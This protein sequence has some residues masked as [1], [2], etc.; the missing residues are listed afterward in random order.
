[1][2]VSLILKCN[3][4]FPSSY[5]YWADMWSFFPRYCHVCY[6]SRPSQILCSNG[7]KYRTCKVPVDSW[8]YIFLHPVVTSSALGPNIPLSTVHISLSWLWTRSGDSYVVSVLKN[9]QVAYRVGELPDQMNNCRLLKKY[10]ASGS[11][12]IGRLVW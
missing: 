8:F 1:M 10:S 4:A 5:S 9:R 11:Y 2:A 6:I 12:L 7:P 3:F